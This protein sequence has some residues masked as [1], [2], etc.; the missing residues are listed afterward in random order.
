MTKSAVA[1]ITVAPAGARRRSRTCF[2]RRR[3]PPSIACPSVRLDVDFIDAKGPVVLPVA[4]AVQ[5]IDARP[6]TV[7]ARPVSDLEV[8]QIL[9]DRTLKEGKLTLEVKATGKGL[10]PN[11][12]ELF[13]FTPAG[14]KMDEIE[15][16]GTAV[17]RLSSEGDALAAASERNWQI[18]LSPEQSSG[19]NS[20]FRFPKPRIADLKVSYKR[21]QDADLVEV[22]PELALAG[23]PLRARQLWPWALLIV[24]VLF[25]SVLFTKQLRSKTAE[26]V[27]EVSYALPPNISPFT[28]LDLLR[29]IHA[30]PRLALSADQ[31]AELSKSIA[32][33]EAYYFA[34]RG[35]GEPRPDLASIG[36]RWVTQTRALAKQWL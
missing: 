1:R 26:A 15:D 29:R 19:R 7:P 31:R 16:S 2:S 20:L 11:F 5:L 22:T 18:K 4:S 30:D 32:G 8:T 9:D 23:L 21:Y 33:I 10:V 17:Q 36:G 34:H 13:D 28:T 35:N 14:F 24:V 25:M 6:D 12:N 27:A 3:T